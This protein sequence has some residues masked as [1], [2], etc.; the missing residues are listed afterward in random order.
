MF[1][2]EGATKYLCDKVIVL[3]QSLSFTWIKDSQENECI[4]GLVLSPDRSFVLKISAAEKARSPR[5]MLA[6]W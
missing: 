2:P 3:F 6:E 5:Q 1:M 4:R